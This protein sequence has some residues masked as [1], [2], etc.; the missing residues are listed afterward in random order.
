V[1]SYLT[2]RLG[3][4]YDMAPTVN[5][6]HSA[7]AS[8]TAMIYTTWHDDDRINQILKISKPAG[9]PLMVDQPAGILRTPTSRATP[10]SALTF[11]VSAAARV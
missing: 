9:V 5:D 11:T 4:E 7:V 2:K 6:L 8:Q 1:G 3:A 10:S